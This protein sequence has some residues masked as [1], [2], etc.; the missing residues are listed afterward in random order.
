MDG[1]TDG[2]L[3]AVQLS[4]ASVWSAHRPGNSRVAHH[5]GGFAA[6][7]HYRSSITHVVRPVMNRA[8]CLA[9]ESLVKQK[10][11]NDEILQ[12]RENRDRLPPSQRAQVQPSRHSSARVIS[13]SRRLGWDTSALAPYFPTKV[14][15]IVM[16]LFTGCDT[17]KSDLRI[18]RQATSHNSHNA[19]CSGSKTLHNMHSLTV[20]YI[21]GAYLQ[22]GEDTWAEVG[23]T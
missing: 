9:G 16:S 7:S 23:T 13:A 5:W 3:F 15:S 18:P 20:P 4:G 8:A 11:I 19:Q 12:C 2:R 1:W 17:M 22:H 6:A 10:K 14:S 21:A